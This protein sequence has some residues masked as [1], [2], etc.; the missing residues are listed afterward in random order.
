MADRAIKF[1]I[2]KLMRGH[3]QRQRSAGREHVAHLRQGKMIVFDVFQHVQA[4]HGVKRL[5]AQFRGRCRRQIELAYLHVGF[6]AKQ[7]LQLVAIIRDDIRC[8]HLTAISAQK[9]CDVSRARTD[10]EHTVAQR[11]CDLLK[12]PVIVLIE[13]GKL[14]QRRRQRH[15]FLCHNEC[16]AL[17]PQRLRLLIM[18]A[19]LCEVNSGLG[20]EPVAS[21]GALRD[22]ARASIIAALFPA[23]DRQAKIK[24]TMNQ[25]AELPTR[26]FGRE[27]RVALYALA[28]LFVVMLA[29]SWQR[30]TQ[31]LLDHGREMNLPTRILAGEQLYSDVQFLYGPLA[32][33]LNALLYGVFGVH[34]ATLRVSG[35]LCAILILLLIYWLARRLMSVWEAALTTGLVLVICAIKSTANYISPYAYAALY[36]LLAALGSLVC[37]L[38]FLRWRETKW[39]AYAGALAGLAI[40]A[41]PEI[42]LAALAANGVALLWESVLIRK[43]LWRETLWFALP[44]L[45]IVAVTYGLILLRVPW[46]VLLNDN[47]VLFSNMPPQLIYFNR[48]VSGLAKW[49]DS[50]W[51]SLTGIAVLGIWSGAAAVIG[52]VIA[53]PRSKPGQGCWHA[54]RISVLVLLIAVGAREAAIRYLHVPTDVTPFAS[55][56]FA[57]PL[58]IGLLVWRAWQTRRQGREVPLTERVLLLLTVFSLFSVL[59]AF[60]NVTTTGPYTPFFLPVLIVVY[61]YLLFRVTLAFLAKPEA[62]R[63]VAQKVAMVLV[64]GLVLGMAANSARRFRSVNTFAVSSARGSFLTL[65]EIGEPLSAAIRY[66][67]QHTKPGEYVLALPVAT[68]INF[69]AA[70]PY[71]LREEIVHPGFLTD[72]KEI[73]AIERIRARQVPLILVTNLITSEFRDRVF[74]ADYNQE[75]MRWITE[76]YHVTARFESNVRQGANFNR[77]PFFILAYER[78]Q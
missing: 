53:I 49:P 6:V 58:L 40:I 1:A 23:V 78:N 21:G 59:R 70:R 71:P 38:Q 67:E 56:I 72:E 76:H 12:Q 77:E 50:F 10:F 48:H 33:Y 60:L 64:G 45:A 26:F 7:T 15:A 22:L 75:L 29:A 2:Q 27:D 47:H 55:A 5:R 46:Q 74:G 61:L 20:E 17:G 68:T 73:E 34:L 4:N 65:P 54:L 24:S 9:L 13:F 52:A 11:A 19:V 69:M 62:V 16:N 63:P 18:P 66:A 32:P 43:L 41:K 44:V 8:Q 42:A 57:L 37:T 30:W 39:F 51:F 36:G 14:S 28:A 25:Q 35:A 31:P 3:Q